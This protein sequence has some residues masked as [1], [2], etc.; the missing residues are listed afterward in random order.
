[1]ISNQGFQGNNGGDGNPFRGNNQ[2]P[3]KLHY[4]KRKKKKGLFFL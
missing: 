4:I 2:F 3:N 1:M